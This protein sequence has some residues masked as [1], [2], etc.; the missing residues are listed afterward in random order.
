MVEVDSTR[1]RRS[2]VE[3]AFAPL[4][5]LLVHADTDDR[6]MYAEYLRREGFDVHEAGTTDSALPLVPDATAVVTGLLVPGS[7]DAVEFI[8]R[9]RRESS[10]PI[11]VLTAETSRERV[12]QARTAGADVVLLK[13]CLPETLFDSVIETID[14]HDIRLATPPARR[15]LSERRAGLRG[16]GRRDSDLS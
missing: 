9:V 13:P 16:G 2:H 8:A 1:P 15:R 5:L 12:E 11:V 3:E 14:A 4:S 10:T 6:A 7:I